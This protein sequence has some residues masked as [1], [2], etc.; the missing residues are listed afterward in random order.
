MKE[1]M[2]KWDGTPFPEMIQGLPEVDVPFDGVRGW[3]LQGERTQVVFFDIEAVGQVPPHSH[4][5]QWGIMIEGEM[6][7]TIDGTVHP[8][9]KGDWYYIPAGATHSATFKQRVQVID[10]FDEPNRYSPK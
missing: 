10:I 2:E 3:L 9:R 1:L 4:G 6:E 8:I 7:L 5:A